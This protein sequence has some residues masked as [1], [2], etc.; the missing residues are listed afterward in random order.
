MLVPLRISKAL[1]VHH[2]CSKKSI[3]CVVFRRFFMS[4]RI[5]FV[6]LEVMLYST[7]Q[8][9]NRRSHTSILSLNCILSLI[10]SFARWGHGR[11]RR[12][13]REGTCD[14]DAADPEQ[15]V[16]PRRQTKPKRSF[17]QGQYSFFCCPQLPH[18]Q[19]RVILISFT[20]SFRAVAAVQGSFD[21]HCDLVKRGQFTIIERIVE[22]HSITVRCIDMGRFM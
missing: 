21:S 18:R 12:R 5:A 17:H 13:S 3:L 9:T 7:I 11:W 10:Q 1:L 8:R 2:F 22:F 15:E 16:L 6:R 4:V 14:E 20:S 19:P